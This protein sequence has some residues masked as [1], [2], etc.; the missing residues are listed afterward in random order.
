MRFYVID[1]RTEIPEGAANQAFLITDNWNDWFK[2]QTQYWLII[3]SPDGNEIDAGSVKIGQFN[4][5]DGQNRPDIPQQ[6]ERL[7]AE[8]FSLGQDDSYYEAIKGLGE[9]PR[10]SVF[11]A[12]RDIAADAAL[13][14]AAVEEEVTRESLLRSVS[15]TAAK[16][17]YR[18]IAGG[19]NR[20]DRYSFGF[21][22]KKRHNQEPPELSFVVE[23]NSQP[24]TNI[25]V[26]IGRNGVGK[27]HILQDLSRTITQIPESDNEPLG[28]LTFEDTIFDDGSLGFSNL[29]SVTF[30]AF[31]PFDPL[32]EPQD[33]TKGFRYAY[34][35]L[36]HRTKS[37]SEPKKPPKTPE[38]LGSDFA[39]SVRL[40]LQGARRSRWE[41]A[42][43]ILESDPIF[44]QAELASLARATD[45]DGPEA[46]QEL[47]QQ[48]YKMLSSGHKIVLLTLTR[49]VETVEERSLV[50]I[51]EP[52]AHLHPPL[53]S[54]F[55]RA[56]SD[57]LTDRNGAAIIATHSPVILQ[58][59]PKS[60][61]W[62]IDRSGPVLTVERPS[63]E[64]FGENVGILTREVFQLEVTHAGFHR[65]LADAV[66]NYGTYEAVLHHFN[67]Q[68]GGEA[69]AVARGL[70]VNRDDGGEPD[71]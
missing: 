30:S 57:L 13:Y 14:A 55:V 70:V 54:A 50:L 48:T 40:C 45:E 49:L 36:K 64:T 42:L 32:P 31:D 71:V 8:F 26:L 24:P 1:S 37:K 9:E 58:E 53:L 65:L 67:S 17:Q 34:V 2:Y 4:W 7:A 62:L 60:C 29:V 3:Y 68:L 56:L 10:T 6:F 35:G 18:R 63:I 25:H 46:A 59:V 16:G 33:K 12:L 38:Q 15:E 52:E 47:A 23:P 44:K 69:K 28:E 51:D 20:L 22:P 39:K 43:E 11:A 21:K 61:A 66:R 27:T 41:R 5:R 19:G